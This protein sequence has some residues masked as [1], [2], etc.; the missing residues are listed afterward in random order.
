VSIGGHLEES[1]RRLIM[2]GHCGLSVPECI[3]EVADHEFS[4]RNQLKVTIMQKAT[5]T[6]PHVVPA[7]I[8]TQYIFRLAVESINTRYEPRS[9]ARLL[10]HQEDR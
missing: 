6:V 1:S 5:P 8:E 2:Y 4:D 3:L 7:H 10:E 9:S